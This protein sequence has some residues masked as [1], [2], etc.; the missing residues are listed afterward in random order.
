MRCEATTAKGR[1]VLLEIDYNVGDVARH[2]FSVGHANDQQ[3]AILFNPMESGVCSAKHFHLYVTG[4]LLPSH[5]K[6]GIYEL[7][8][9]VAPA[10]KAPD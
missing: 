10:P 1:K 9:E 3:K 2:V 4:D 5:R 6:A 7:D 8:A